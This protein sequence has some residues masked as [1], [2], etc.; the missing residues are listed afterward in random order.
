[1]GVEEFIEQEYPVKCKGRGFDGKE[2][3][4]ET[5]DVVVKIYKSPGSSVISSM[6]GCI[7]NR[8]CHG[9][10]CGASDSINLVICP[11]SFDLPHAF[12]NRK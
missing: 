1:M 10:G 11:Y 12:D 2:V 4:K 8:G 6:V 7:Y 5:I 9:E 3:L